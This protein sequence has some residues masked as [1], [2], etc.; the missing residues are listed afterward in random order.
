[1]VNSR[2][3]TGKSDCPKTSPQ[4][5]WDHMDKQKAQTIKPWEAA[6]R[7]G[8]AT[9]LAAGMAGTPVVALADGEAQDDGGIQPLSTNDGYYYIDDSS[10]GLSYYLGQAASNGYA[11][12]HVGTSFSD[13]GTVT[14]PSSLTEIAGYSEGFF[15]QGPKT[16]SIGYVGALSFVIPSGSDVSIDRV[17]FYAKSDDGGA[18]VTVDAGV[19]VKFSNC[20]FSK[21][22]VVNGEAIFEDCTFATGKIENNGTATYVGRP[23]SPKTSAS[24]LTRTSRFR[25][26]SRAARRSPLQSREARSTRISRLAWRERRRRTQSSRLPSSMPRAKMWRAFPR[27]SKAARCRFRARLLRRAAIR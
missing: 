7:A 20:A 3:D 23:K 4:K 17:N 8:V 1:M 22:P 19:K 16:V 9:V 6:A 26:L 11:K 5:G 2:V 13:S 21:T 12:V 18:T 24:L 10:Y 14:I 15:S 25:S 27:R